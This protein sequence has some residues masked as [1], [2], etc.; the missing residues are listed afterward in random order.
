[1]VNAENTS[2]GYYNTGSLESFTVK[3]VLCVLFA[4]KFVCTWNA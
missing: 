3:T 2:H 1:M 4:G